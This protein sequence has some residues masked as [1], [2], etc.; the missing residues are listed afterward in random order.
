VL[1]IGE[2][3]GH[4]FVTDYQQKD[5]CFIS[6]KNLGFYIDRTVAKLLIPEGEM[7][8]EKETRSVTSLEEGAHH[9]YLGE[10]HL[11]PLPSLNIEKDFI[12][13]RKEFTNS[14]VF[15]GAK[16]DSL[17]QSIILER[18]HFIN[19][20]DLTKPCKCFMRTSANAVAIPVMLLFKT[21]N[22]VVA[23]MSEPIKHHLH[24]GMSIS[25]YYKKSAG[26]K[27][28][29]AGIIVSGGEIE[30]EDRI[31]TKNDLPQDEEELARLRAK[32]Q[33]LDFK[34]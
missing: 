24:K 11:K 31:Y 33:E 32:R 25:F 8:Y 28:I 22:I 30:I 5:E 34:F 4:K 19:R 3:M 9:Y 15:I 20:M 7:I 14:Q 27:L 21:N 12:V 18:F 2:G 29:G 1:K 13:T 26:A 10:S 6:D 17:Y 23:Q 16:V